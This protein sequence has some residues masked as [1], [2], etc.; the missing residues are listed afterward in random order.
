MSDRPT[1]NP[2]KTSAAPPSQTDSFALRYFPHTK[3]SPTNAR[4]AHATATVYGTN[5]VDQDNLNL[6]AAQA[7][8]P[9]LLLNLVLSGFLD[10]DHNNHDA[11]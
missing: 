10:R 3:I 5:F 6:S 4:T 9:A 11:A 1:V 2:F 8:R 7:Q